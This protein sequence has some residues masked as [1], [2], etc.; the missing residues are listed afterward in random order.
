MPVKDKEKWTKVMKITMMSSEESDSD[1]NN[2][3]IIVKPLQWRSAIVNR[4]LLKL[5]DKL[6]ETKSLQARRQRKNRVTGSVSS[7]RE[8]PKG[9]PK[10][11][12]VTETASQS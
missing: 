5:D 3:D 1:P 8:V 2:D 6:M 4:F 9:A 12:I 10:W 11:A 7:E